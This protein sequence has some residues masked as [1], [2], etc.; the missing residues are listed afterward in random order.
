[1]AT[2][3]KNTNP[4]TLEKGTYEII[5]DRLLKQGDQLQKK[6]QQLNDARKEVFGSIP[7]QLISTERITTENNCTPQDMVSLNDHF[8]FG[9]NVHLGLKTVT[10]LEDVFS[11]YHYEDQSFHQ[12]DLKLLQ[13]KNFVREFDNLYKY[14]KDTQF[15]K[16]AV[17]GP[18]LYMIFQIGE[19]ASDIKVFKWQINGNQLI[20]SEDR[21]SNEFQYPD[22][23]EFSWKKVSREMFRDGLHPHI[24]IED[25]VFVETVGGD[26]T[27]KVEDNTDDGK[28]IYSEI[29]ENQ[30]QT[31]QDAE[32]YYSIVR[33]LIFLKIRPYKEEQ[34]RYIIYNKKIQQAMRVDGIENACVLLPEDYGVIFPKGYYLQTGEHKVFDNDLKSMLF[35][36]RI[37]SPNGE[38]FL[39]VFY[40]P[41]S[42]LYVLLSYNLIEQTVANPIICHGYSFFSNGELCYFKQEE[43]PQKHHAIQIWQTPYVSDINPTVENNS[44][45]LAKV[46][47]KDIVKGMAEGHEILNL[48]TKKDTYSNLYIDIVKKV[49][50]IIDSFHWLN[51]KDAFNLQDTL[52]EIKSVAGTAID[53]FD[54]VIKIKKNTKE[55]FSTAEA[56]IKELKRELK[57]SKLNNIDQFVKLLAKLRTVRGAVISLKDLRYID[58]AA[59]EL[60]EEELALENDKLSERCVKF[61]LK[62]EAL[63]YYQQKIDELN[64]AVEQLKKVVEANT[65][66]EEVLNTSTELEMLIEIVSNLKIEDA[67]L[68]TTIINNISEIYASFNQINSALKRKRKELFLV[69]GKAEFNSQLKLISQ[70]IINY[71]DISDT[72]EKC[73]EYLSK[74]M[75]QLEELES[76]F[77]EFEE[78][79]EKISDKRNEAYNAFES[80]KVQL[81]EKRNKRTAA[82]Q[83]SANRILSGVKN[84]LEGLE[85]LN[86]IN[87]Y[88][89]SDLMVDK[90]RNIVK[91]LIELG[92]TVKAD[93]VQG[94]I[95]STKED[96]IR[97]LRDRTELFEGENLISFGKHK[98]S[99]N[100]QLLDLTIV[101]RNDSMYYHITGTN[102][103]EEIEDQQLLATQAVWEQDVIS[104]NKEVYKSEYLA[105]QAFKTIE[106]NKEISLA[107]VNLWTDDERL[108]YVIKIMTPRYNE[109]YVKGIHDHDASLILKE[110]LQFSASSGVLRYSPEVRIFAIYFWSFYLNKEVRRALFSEIN[111]AGIILKAFPNSQVFDQLI[112]RIAGSIEHFNEQQSIFSKEVQLKESA[113]YLFEEL[114]NNAIFS[115][116]KEANQLQLAFEKHL[117]QQKLEKDFKDSIQKLESEEQKFSLIKSW[118]SAFA[119]TQKRPSTSTIDEAALV[120]SNK[121]NEFQL[122]NTDFKKEIGPLNGDHLNIKDQILFID[123]HDFNQ[124]LKHFIE[125]TVPAFEQFNRL[126]KELIES[127]K[128]ELK[129]NELKPKVMNSFVRNQLINK[130][131]LPI[132]GDN[133]AKQ[134]GTADA[135][136]R[137]DLMG[138]LLL[139]SPPGYGKTTLMEYIASRL[140][141]IFL[142]INGPA[143]GHE[144]TSLDPTEAP[145]AGAREEIEKLNL[146][147]EMGDNV[148]IYLDD[149][150]HCNPEF[151]Q[152]FISLC[153]AQRKIEGVYKGKSKTYDLRGKKVSVVM[154]GNPYTESGDKF[155]IP[156]MLANRAD[157]Y[158]LGDILGGNEKS[159]ELSYI[160]NCLTS[161]TTLRK[162]S[163]K[164]QSDLYSLI[165]IAETDDHENVEFESN[166]S[167][168]DIKDYISVLK[169]LI[170]VRDVVLKV[171]QEYIRSAAME[172]QYRTE[173]S[174]RL[175]GSY[176]NMN[177]MAEKI[178][179]IMNDE[180]IET[181]ILSNY[182]NESQ[183]L[184]SS[185]EANLLKFKEL[186]EWQSPVESDRWSELKTIFQKG[187]KLKG[188][189]DNNQM[190]MILNQ[191]EALTEGLQGIK[192]ALSQ[193]NINTTKQ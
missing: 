149:I 20:Y 40:N 91:E 107:N 56:K 153:D 192:N 36:K 177:K 162:L 104:E 83:S 2:A 185:A 127:Y 88:M 64:Q 95:K 84:R 186:L 63:D 29:V 13:D 171:N 168:E 71:L 187:Q 121:D 160:E 178:A 112:N 179:P 166:H 100:N 76:R 4:T 11:I 102:F 77:S 133:L 167:A 152:K 101:P 10:H 34:F 193:Q 61:L 47:N 122:V 147:L 25:Q 57:I 189:G 48:I 22:Q 114:S 170:Q 78:F 74:L 110:L 93:D 191:M 158:N 38:D 18:F 111:G 143:I 85:D 9:Y 16:F 188:F 118:I 31:L 67:T 97:Q 69:E 141:V 120:L 3:K 138:M 126:K 39:Y 125:N 184:T 105:Y 123:F 129:L 81:I 86:A 14:Y 174:F 42:G 51:K 159:F 106:S 33:N 90:L 46:G 24:S 190:G 70:G 28:G 173:P 115:V 164:N 7:T 8:I 26:L 75:V 146:G 32:I 117:K 55:E 182:E 137:T 119:E 41:I 58:V 1:M 183:T 94:K 181:L 144:L 151:L 52:S 156:D 23:H 116:S 68:T 73:D 49:T 99:V 108:E 30:D 21:A 175:Q 37:E 17:I 44:S 62:K 134:I 132:I 113:T 12:K 169:K 98:F 27:I 109:G 66:E 59:V 35:E 135:N 157:I 161:N 128:E 165:Q 163:S 172:E 136:K 103:F 130:V 148:M 60:H 89:A 43:E 145:N 176:R 54:R 15:S 154:A 180:E 155:Q 87:G 82:L 96:A 92:D 5:R 53:E 45:F 131:Y 139:I 124:R 140:G 50:V 79:L 80:R 65:L 142:K 150:Q 72:A 19:Q 6:L